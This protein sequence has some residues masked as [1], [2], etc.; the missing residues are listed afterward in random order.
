MDGM[1]AKID[2]GRPVEAGL[3]LR[4]ERVQGQIERRARLDLGKNQERS[5]T[6]DQVNLTKRCPI[7]FRQH[8]KTLEAAAPGRKPLCKTAT[9]LR[10]APDPAFW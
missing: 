9:P 4:T 6:H 3:L 7:T 10:T 1:I 5:P 8:A 2:F